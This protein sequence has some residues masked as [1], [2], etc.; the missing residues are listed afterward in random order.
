MK[1]IIT[2]NPKEQSNLQNKLRANKIIFKTQLD[3]G[4]ALVEYQ[5]KN[6]HELIFNLPIYYIRHTFKVDEIFTQT[7]FDITLLEKFVL[8]NINKNQNFSFQVRGNSKDIDI[9]SV[10]QN[11]QSQGYTLN[12]KYPE[13][14]ISILFA[15]NQ[16]FVGVGNKTTN[17]TNFKGG[18]YH[19]SSKSNFISRAEYKL[20][21]AIDCFNID[22]TSL[23]YALDLGAAP[24]GWSKVLADKNLT[25]Y[26]VDPAS[27]DEKL[28]RNKNI[29]HF[30][31]TAQEFLKNN[32]QKFDILVN[33]MKMDAQESISLT[34]TLKPFLNQNAYIVLT[35]KLANNHKSSQIDKALDLLS[36]TYKIITARQLFHNRSEITVFAKNNSI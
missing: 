36:K 4:I 26:S 34:S 11:L 15:K 30:K 27:L 7:N 35:L 21:E 2:Y 32:K 17:L 18:D 13:Q 12:V 31:Q 20:L 19:F 16:I 25:V 28:N 8:N 3:D 29:I 33:D 6:L 14:I 1:Y 24:G 5:N 23:N 9:Y 22:L 10:A